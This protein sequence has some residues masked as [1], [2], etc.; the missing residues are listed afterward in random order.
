MLI[1][2]SFDAALRWPFLCEHRDLP[3]TGRHS[4]VTMAP[5]GP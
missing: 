4:V 5:V 1:G 2:G 3:S